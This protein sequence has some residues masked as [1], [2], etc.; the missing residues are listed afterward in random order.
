M[1]EPKETVRSADLDLAKKNTL[2]D[3]T[4]EVLYQLCKKC[5]K[6]Q[7]P[8]EIVAKVLLIGR[9]YAAAIER[10]PHADKTKTNEDFYGQRVVN[11]MK[12]SGIDDWLAALPKATANPRECAIQAI[13]AHLKLVLAFRELT[14]TDKRALASKY[15]HFHRPDIFFIY[16]SRAQS[17]IRRVTPDIRFVS[18]P[19]V[20]A[21]DK[22][23][24]YWE[25]F[26]RCLW[27]RQELTERWGQ[28]PTPRE[29]DNILL[30]SSR[31]SGE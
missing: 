10:R 11:K 6:H 9:A 15:L 30:T 21:K 22:D 19:K 3:V 20:G 13:E 8:S 12:S 24:I 17:A 5:P 29:I 4:N 26:S 25:F 7:D 1:K 2:W 31:V 14:D 28:P 23:E 16:D 18:P 27:L